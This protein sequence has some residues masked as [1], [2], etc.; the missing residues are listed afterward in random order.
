MPISMEGA[1]HKMDENKAKQ[2]KD[3]IANAAKDDQEL[4]DAIKDAINE[5]EKLERQMAE[6]A[7]TLLGSGKVQKENADFVGSEADNVM[8]AL[9]REQAKHDPE[10]AALLKE[11]DESENQIA[12]LT[13]ILGSV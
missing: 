11:I 6:I 12:G 2:A 9:A 7:E 3:I 8:M 1:Y 13:D 5:L 4:K 10:L